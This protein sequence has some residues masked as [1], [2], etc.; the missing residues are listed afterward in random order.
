MTHCCNR[1]DSILAGTYHDN[2]TSSPLETLNHLSI[3]VIFDSPSQGSFQTAPLGSD[4][5]DAKTLFRFDFNQIGATA[6]ESKSVSVGSWDTNQRYVFTI[7]SPP[8]LSF[9]I[10]VVPQSGS[11]SSS[12]TLYHGRVIP[13]VVEKTF[14]QKYQS[15]MLIALF[16][17]LNILVKSQKGKETLAR[18]GGAAAQQV[19]AQGPQPGVAAA[20]PTAAITNGAS[21]GNG[22]MRKR[23]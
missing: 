1:L 18:M 14:L 9:S 8:S 6:A 15:P 11:S 4:F 10:S 3:R 5:S 21:N 23:K 19:A 22:A 13:V 16:L 2:S 20:R 17:I 7:D 12:A